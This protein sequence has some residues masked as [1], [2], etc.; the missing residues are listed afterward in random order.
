MKL[1]KYRFLSS[2]I[3]H[4]TEAAP[5]IEQVILNKQITCAD[6][7]LED[8]LALVLQEAL[9]GKYTVED[10]EPEAG[11]ELTQEERIADLE[12]AL[13]LLLSGETE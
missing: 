13:A 11:E 4:G 3:N 6:E 10:A 12:E 7:A 9:D 1:I 2:E 5:D 8:T